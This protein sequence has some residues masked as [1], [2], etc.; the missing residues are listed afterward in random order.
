MD[1]LKEYRDNFRKTFQ[2]G[3]YM[4]LATFFLLW[5]LSLILKAL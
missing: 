3:K 2:L 5:L 4:M 1:K